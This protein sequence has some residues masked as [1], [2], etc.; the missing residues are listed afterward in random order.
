MYHRIADAELDPWGLAVSPARFEA[1]VEAL[2]ASRRILPLCEFAAMHRAGNLAANALAI[3]FDD[4]YACNRT[5]AAPILAKHG[6]PATVFVTTGQIGS[7]REFWWD[8]LARLFFEERSAGEFAL[9]VGGETFSFAFGPAADAA[10]AFDA[11]APPQNQRQASYLRVWQALRDCGA[12]ERAAAMDRLWKDTL[13]TTPPPARPSH[14]TMSADE[15]RG[16]ARSGLVEIG[17]HTVHHPAL[18]ALDVAAQK[19]EIDD[20]RSTCEDLIGNPPRSFAYPHG[21]YTKETKAHVRAAG[22]E[23]ACTTAES[24]VRP[25]ADLLELPRL[26][27]RDRDADA[28]MHAIGALETASRT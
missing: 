19:R 11:C 21:A 10:V 12:E 5:V 17:A 25:G 26:Q 7:D 9:P 22:F 16:L 28:L 15:I 8:E 2:K 18:S 27:V 14:R 3:T 4:G 1:Q 6:A 20:S 23:V 13:G 24:G